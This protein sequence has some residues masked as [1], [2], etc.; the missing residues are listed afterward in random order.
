MT[1][2][3]GGRHPPD[4]GGNQD[5]TAAVSRPQHG[6][7]LM[8]SA[9]AVMGPVDVIVSREEDELESPVPWLG[10]AIR[11]MDGIVEA[12]T[13]MLSLPH[14]LE[15]TMAASCRNKQRLRSGSAGRT[16]PSCGCG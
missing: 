2:R 1:I 12:T 7:A 6:G 5:V 3:G 13:C 9:D 10:Q 4:R 11:P 15:N 16:R 8:L 14:S